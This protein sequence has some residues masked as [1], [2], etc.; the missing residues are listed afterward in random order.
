MHL[1][2]GTRIGA[3]EITGPLGKGGMGEVYRA[4]DTR[5]DRDVAIK[6]LPEHLARDPE[7]LARFEREAKILAQL[8]HPNVAGIYG[9]EV[10]EGAS[11]LVLEYAP[12][13]SLAAR[14]S[15]GALPLDE[16]LELAVEIAAGVEAAHEAGVIHR[17][18]KPGNVMVTP[19]G[20]AKVLDFGLARADETSSSVT[21][22]E[23]SPTLTSPAQHSPTIA[24]V[25]LGTAAY[26]SPEQ[27]RGR[28]IDKRTDIWSFG[29]VLY[30]ML[31]GFGPF[32]GET[33]SDSIGAVLHK[34]VDLDSLPA[35]TPARVRHVLRRCLERDR[36]QRLRDIGDAR[37]ELRASPPERDVAEAVPPRALSRSISFSATAL[38]LGAALGGVLVWLAMHRV[39]PPAGVTRFDIDLQREGT[40][41]FGSGPPFALSPDGRR[42]A[43]IVQNDADSSL[44]V[45]GIDEDDGRRLATEVSL[46]HPFFSPDGHW[47]AYF[48]SDK[49]MKVSVDGG[50]PIVL[51]DGEGDRSRGGTWGPDGTIVFAPDTISPLMRVGAE[52]GQVSAITTLDASRQERSHRWPSFVP[53]RRDRLVFTSETYTQNFE[54]SSIEMLDLSSGERHVLAER[55]TYGQVTPGGR[56]I[57]ARGG[58]LFGCDLAGDL[59][60]CVRPPVPIVSDLTAATGNGGAQFAFS[61]TGV[62]IYVSGVQGGRGTTM[63]SWIDFHG[64]ET[65]LLPEPAALFSPA[66]SPDG[67]RIAFQEG[68]GTIAVYEIRRGILSPVYPTEERQRRPVW[69]PDGK[70]IVF[71]ST[72]S[73]NFVPSLVIVSANG[74]KAPVRIGSGVLSE[75]NSSDWSRDGEKILFDEAQKTTRYDIFI[76][77]VDSG[78]AETVIASPGDDTDG[79]FS[80]DG[81]W[82]AY[83][84]NVSGAQEIYLHHLGGSGPRLQVSVGGGTKPR[85]APDGKAIYYVTTHPAPSGLGGTL[86]Q[87]PID[88]HAE[89]PSIGAPKTAVELKPNLAGDQYDLDPSGE[90]ILALKWAWA[91]E[92]ESRARI[93]LV[94]NW[95]SEL[96]RKLAGGGASE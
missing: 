5:L 13:E 42:L 72:T 73:E 28:R 24:G 54:E 68:P 11:Y 22:H 3:Y 83:Q 59:T 43:Y 12:G 69:S 40:M 27:A 35:G 47:I 4:R 96:D 56:L 46:A 48:S 50:S 37:I 44:Y 23:N 32:R 81:E 65:P 39:A 88:L 30:E 58:A 61:E 94:M 77:H 17:D 51:V 64:R 71:S 6:V 70:Q 86:W 82:I 55:G 38:A 18:L 63:P 92:G 34:N 93:H 49:L 21:V 67:S 53:G 95:F 45:R 80:P 16:A 29:V 57:F 41:G 74:E 15:R 10:H 91:H 36:N 89:P 62:M 78:K 52:G 84:S 26:M 85:W 87:V 2:T 79:R 14:L 60:S 8:N 1:A 90:R 76:H 66:I 33:V 20:K 31:T 25:I 9:V 75:Q 7:R 19:D